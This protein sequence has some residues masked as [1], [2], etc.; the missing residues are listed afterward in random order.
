MPQNLVETPVS[1]LKYGDLNGGRLAGIFSCFEKAKRFCEESPEMPDTIWMT[2]Y[3]CRDV[4]I[5]DWYPLHK[6]WIYRSELS[7]S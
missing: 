2:I 7:S 6:E 5:C 1:I 3:D 4:A